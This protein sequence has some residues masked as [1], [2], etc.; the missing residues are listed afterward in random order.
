[1]RRLQPPKAALAL[2]MPPAQKLPPSLTQS[3]GKQ[4][5]IYHPG[6]HASIPFRWLNTSHSHVAADV[7]PEGG[8]S[9]HEPVPERR[10]GCQEQWQY[11]SSTDANSPREHIS[12]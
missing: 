10:P 8:Q 3:Q 12:D 7:V 6:D 5:P 2:V 9:A 11:S 1:M 4:D